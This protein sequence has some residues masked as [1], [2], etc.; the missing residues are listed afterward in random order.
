M[1]AIFVFPQELEFYSSIWLVNLVLAASSCWSSEGR[2]YCAH[3]QMSLPGR[4]CTVLARGPD[5]VKVVL[6]LGGRGSA[7]NGSTPIFSL[8][9]EISHSQ[10]TVSP[11]RKI[12]TCLPGFHPNSVHLACVWAFLSQACDSILSLQTLWT[13]AVGTHAV[14]PG[15]GMGVFLG[16]YVWR[17]M[18]QFRVY[19]Y[20]EQKAHSWAC[21]LQSASLLQCLGTVSNL[22]TPFFLW[23][24]GS[25]NHSVPPGVRAC[26]AT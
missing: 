5:S 1:N 25:W 12:I 9:A 3:S 13:L 17:T 23:P 22:V 11:H 15:V 4:N 20:I 7:E 6:E 2:A 14:P 19:G 26:F 21:C 24:R 16:F 18:R 8:G 10:S